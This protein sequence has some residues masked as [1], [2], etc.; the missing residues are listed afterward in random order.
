MGSRRGPRSARGQPHLLIHASRAFGF[1]CSALAVLPMEE[2]ISRQTVLLLMPSIRS[3]R[4]CGRWRLRGRGAVRRRF[5][6]QRTAKSL[7]DVCGG[8]A[9]RRRRGAKMYDISKLLQKRAL[10]CSVRVQPRTTLCVQYSPRPRRRPAGGPTSC[11]YCTE[12]YTAFSWHAASWRGAI[13]VMGR[14]R[15]QGKVARACQPRRYCERKCKVCARHGS[16][17]D[18]AADAR[19]WRRV[20]WHCDSSETYINTA[21]T[22]LLRELIGTGQPLQSHPRSERVAA[23]AGRDCKYVSSPPCSINSMI[24]HGAASRSS[25][26]PPKQRTMCGESNDFISARV[27][28]ISIT[29]ARDHSSGSQNHAHA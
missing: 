20:W 3:L 18:G 10:K 21:H 24:M 11:C 19:V 7:A 2:L 12:L 14:C 8:G 13:A 22:L 29:A 23:S 16:D 25:A 5:H 27:A 15:R 26:P 28:G 6:I 9:R 17:G 4:R 1:F